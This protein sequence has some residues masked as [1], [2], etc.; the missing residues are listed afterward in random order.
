MYA[1][2]VLPVATNF[3]LFTNMCFMF[4]LPAMF[5]GSYQ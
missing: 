2:M 3:W 5:W 1:L 4:W